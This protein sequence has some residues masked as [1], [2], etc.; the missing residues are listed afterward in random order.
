MGHIY[1]FM[2]ALGLWCFAQAFSS[3]SEWELL[4][5][6]GAQASHCSDWSSCRAR[7]LGLN[8]SKEY[9]ILLDQGLNPHPLHW[10]VY[11]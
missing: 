10:Q 3:C 5:N 7:V 1:L 9:G 2:A 8:C 11:S 4:S 6:C